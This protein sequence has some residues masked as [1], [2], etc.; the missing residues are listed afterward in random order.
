MGKLFS[1]SFPGFH[2]SPELRDS[3]GHG[4][5]HFFMPIC[6]IK[7]NKIKKIYCNILYKYK[8]ILRGMPNLRP[9]IFYIFYVCPKSRNS[10]LLRPRYLSGTSPQLLLRLHRWTPISGRFVTCLTQA[11]TN[12][13]D[14][15][16][17]ASRWSPS[18]T[19]LQPAAYHLPQIPRG[20][21]DMYHG[22]RP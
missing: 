5:N 8:Y 20:N 16:P 18:S 11:P 2:G 21:H 10:L 17:A 19:L 7:S 1:A 22:T 3:E 4:P 9:N 12:T 13:L 15:L 6:R 14:Q